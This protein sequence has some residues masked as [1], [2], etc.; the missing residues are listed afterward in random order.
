MDSPRFPIIEF[1]H[2]D[3]VELP[4]FRRVRL[5]QPLGVA[6]GDLANPV[7]QALAGIVG[8]NRL[9]AG[10][11]I[12]VAIGSRGISRIDEVAIAVVAYLKQRGYKPFIVPGMGSHGGGTAEG[13]V[14]V[15][16]KLGITEEKVGCEIR[17]TMETVDYGEI[18]PGIRSRFDKNAAGADGV[19]VVNRVKAHTSFDRPIESG[20]VKM[21]AVG[22][23]KQEGA[24][25]VHLTGPRG[26]SE[27]LPKLAAR[28][29]E[30]ASICAGLALMEDAAKNL[31]HVG[32]VEVADFFTND[33]KLLKIAKSMM[34]LLPFDQMD[35]LI[36][37]EI[38]KDISGTGVDPAISGR[39]DIRGLSNPKPFI[40]KLAILG[41]TVKSEGNAMGIGLADYVTHEAVENLDLKS[42]YMNG[43]TATLVEKS[44][45]PVVLKNDRVVMKAVAATCWQIETAKMRI[46]HIR[47]S[48]FLH[49]VMMSEPLYEE[50]RERDGVEALSEP[51]PP[52]FDNQGKLTSRI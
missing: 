49:E 19:V 10:A 33:E 3:N 50:I 4:R 40:H 31:I 46:A 41:L 6:I 7:S 12:A 15:L 14:S 29:L 13:Q 48:L 35:G 9:A 34:A 37:E 11:S 39:A 28:A 23:G 25:N 45:I 43:L 18:E 24:L 2:L 42:I 30:R 26:L 51:E 1:P 8:L 47:N 38:G 5:P 52:R 44:R 20:I 32:G 16:G 22:L 36:V 17:S 21:V 27:I